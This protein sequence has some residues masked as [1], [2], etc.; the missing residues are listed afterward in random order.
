M[1]LASSS[2][3]TALRLEDYDLN[4]GRNNTNHHTQLFGEERLIVRRGQPFNIT[5]Q[6]KPDG[7]RFTLDDNS[8]FL[9]AETGSPTPL[10]CK[11]GHFDDSLSE[12]TA[13]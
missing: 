3:H 12:L 10:G 2:M 7:G 6:V 1:I 4:I 9:I 13:N 5:L 8:F 11:S